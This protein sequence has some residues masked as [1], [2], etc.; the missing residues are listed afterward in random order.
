MIFWSNFVCYVALCFLVSYQAQ[1]LSFL[2]H[3]SRGGHRLGIWEN[4]F[5]SE[6][7]YF[8]ITQRLGKC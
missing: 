4:I 1:R 5:E 8:G 3:L 7:W 6:L 2:T